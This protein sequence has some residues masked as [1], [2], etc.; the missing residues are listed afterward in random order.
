MGKIIQ[1]TVSGHDRVYALTEDGKVYE[2]Y[3]YRPNNVGGKGKWIEL[4]QGQEE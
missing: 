2:W 1:I 4:R 3:P